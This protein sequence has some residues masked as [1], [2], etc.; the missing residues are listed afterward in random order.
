MFKTFM[1]QTIAKNC[2][3]K[4]INLSP[5]LC[6]L[7]QFYVIHFFPLNILITFCNFIQFNSFIK[8]KTFQLHLFF[9]KFN[10]IKFGN[11]NIYFFEYYSL[12][13]ENT[14]TSHA[15]TGDWTCNLSLLGRT[16]V[17]L[18]DHKA[19]GNLVTI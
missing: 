13:I 17:M 4:Y 11:Y 18:L 8:K 10:L 3:K 5:I 2:Y 1:W 12:F 15:P 14:F 6:T 9:C 7:G 16:T 19:F